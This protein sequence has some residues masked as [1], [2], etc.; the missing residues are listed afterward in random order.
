[1]GVLWLGLAPGYISRGPLQNIMLT[2]TGSDY[3]VQVYCAALAQ[4]SAGDEFLDRAT[5]QRFQVK[6]FSSQ[7]AR[8]AAQAA[9]PSCRVSHVERQ[10]RALRKSIRL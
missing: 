4:S 10:Q 1:M 2:F 8:E 9:F 7:D 6:A 5:A 3:A